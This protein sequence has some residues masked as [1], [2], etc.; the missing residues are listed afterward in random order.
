MEEMNC[1]IGRQPI[2]NEYEETVAYELLFRSTESRDNASINDAS[3][4]TAS[5]I[6]NTLSDFGLEFIIGEHRG[7]INLDLEMLMS[8]SI[9]LLPKDRIVFEL[10]E[11]LEVTPELV[12][13][14]RY[15]KEEGFTLALDDH[16]YD[17]VYNDLYDIVDIIKVDLMISPVERLAEMIENFRP[18][19]IKLLAE[20]VETRDEY[21]LCRDLGFE[22]FQGYYFA[23]PSLIEKKKLG[24]SGAIMIKL[25]KLLSEDADLETVEKAFRSNPGLTYRLLLLVN[26]VSMGLR[27]KVNNIRH[28]ISI[29]GRK[30]IM[31]W[32]QLALFA[33]D[34]SRGVNNPLVEMAAVRGAMME[35]LAVMMPELER[36]PEAPD[37]AFM[38]GI[39]SLIDTIYDISMN[40]VL[41]TLNLSSNIRDALVR[42]Q[43]TYGRLLE[44]VE[45][46]ENSDFAL[47]KKKIENLG[48]SED[49]LLYAQVKAYNWHTESISDA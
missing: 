16:Q 31:R 20:K 37:N 34:D 19:G 35:E 2:L 24:E 40:E 22:L 8:D 36:D 28:A 32:V 23:K 3:F 43:G 7:F 45:L 42:R 41:E 13:R 25:L 39:L 21:L 5:V 17:P 18:Y 9:Q 29:L 15:L 33:T 38:T 30:Q 47:M 48:I 44:L 46:C 49:E 6:I 4:A 14:C 26:S 11:N 27:E 12:D 1:L 10:L